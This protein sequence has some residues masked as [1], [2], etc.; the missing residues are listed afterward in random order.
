MLEGQK[1]NRRHL[2]VT[3]QLAIFR[4]G[5]D[6]ELAI[7]VNALV[8]PEKLQSSNLG[9]GELF[10][11]AQKAILLMPADADHVPAQVKQPLPHSMNVPH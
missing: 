3:E 1:L 10:V 7:N 4:E 6:D 8:A 9:L 5:W 11:T 2:P